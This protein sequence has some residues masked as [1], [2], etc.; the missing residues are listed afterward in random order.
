MVQQ[1][2]PISESKIFGTHR[3]SVAKKGALSASEIP[4]RERLAKKVLS[5]K[6]GVCQSFNSYNASHGIITQSAL[7]ELRAAGMR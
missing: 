6:S 2:V 7:L 5:S 3:E 4:T 1:Q